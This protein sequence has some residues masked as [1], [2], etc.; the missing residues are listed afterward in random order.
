[1]NVSGGHFTVVGLTDEQY[2]EDNTVGDYYTAVY[3][4]IYE[5]VANRANTQLGIDW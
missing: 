2:I 1:M 3:M 4:Y 5:G